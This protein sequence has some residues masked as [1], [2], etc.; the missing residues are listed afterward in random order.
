[1]SLFAVPP[2]TSFF[3]KRKW[4]PEK[5]ARLGQRNNNI[6]SKPALPGEI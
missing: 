4:K 2:H 3:E 5:A 1:M 6:L